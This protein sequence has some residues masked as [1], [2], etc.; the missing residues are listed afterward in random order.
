MN[1]IK[2]FEQPS[3]WAGLAAIVVALEPFINNVAHAHTWEAISVAVLSGAIAIVK[4]ES[5]KTETK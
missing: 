2:K 3:S 4:N 1:L 5:S